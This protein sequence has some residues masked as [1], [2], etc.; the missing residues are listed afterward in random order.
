MVPRS[1]MAVLPLVCCLLAVPAQAR[2]EAGAAV[3]VS[4][5]APYYTLTLGWAGECGGDVLDALFTGLVEYAPGTSRMTYAMA[6]SIGTKD[7]RRFTVR[8][9]EGWRFH[10]G[11]EV[12]AHNFVDAWN[13]TAAAGKSTNAFLFEDIKGY[14]SRVMS[15]LRVVDDHTFTIELKRP[16]G[17]FTQKLGHV[18]FSPLPDSVLK[19]PASFERKPVGNGP[20]KVV[21]WA[22]G[23][24][25]VLERYDGYAGSFKARAGKLT[26]RT[27]QDDNVAYADLV[28]GRLDAMSQV[29]AAAALRAAKDL[30]GRV[31]HSVTGNVQEI[32]I[33]LRLSTN[34]DFRKAVSMAIDRKTIAREVFRGG[35]VPADSFVP[36]TAEGAKSGACGAFCRYDP[37]RAR[38]YLA[39]A[40]AKGFRTP[41]SIPL[42][43]AAD[44][45][46]A[47]WV[48]AVAASVGKVFKGAVTIVPTTVKTFDAFQR[49]TSKGTVKGMFRMGWQLDFPHIQNVLAPQFASGGVYNYGLYR[50]PR[51]DALLRAADGQVSR[52]KAIAL[53][54]EAESLL[55]RDMPAIPLW[56]Y[57]AE[58]GY[59]SKIAAPALTPFGWL[60][61][62]SVRPA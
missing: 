17:P 26:Y 40:K 30:R 53:Y 41:A 21:K 29:P 6:K 36:P 31:I 42:Y 52:A 38:T 12:K 61:P 23:T 19:S 24:E 43:Y 35:R 7:N 48:K 14:G 49:M 15:G 54:R 13:Q 18:A 8:L 25:T 60:D 59:S 4:T 20:F 3:T 16:L 5:C 45:G 62:A 2:A 9:R 10:D 32:G 50:N 22:P 1:A 28:V 39:R 55:V 47:D 56:F 51:F 57:Q 11:T 44:S 27:Y 34:A 58:A 46:S 37:A 33:P